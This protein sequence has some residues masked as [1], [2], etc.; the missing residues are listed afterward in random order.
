MI[1]QTVIQNLQ[2]NKTVFKDLL[3]GLSRE[4]YLWK[5]QPEKWCLLE[6]ICHLYDEEREDFRAR[7][8]S[9]LEGAEGAW[10]TIAPQEW[11]VSRRY[12]EQDY[13]KKITDFIAERDKSIEWLKSL[14][15]PDWKSSYMHP[16]V[17][18][19]SAQLLLNNWLAHDYLH[20]RQI[21]KLKYDHLEQLSTEKLDYAGV[22]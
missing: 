17:G 9:V 13:E 18:P 3:S 19:V 5:Q 11:P 2:G 4:D 20:I 15:N 8:K 22:W 21:T 12:M 6:I 16:K 7:L 1:F 14:K 10:P